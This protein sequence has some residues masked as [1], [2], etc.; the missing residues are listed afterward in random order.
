[1][2][3]LLSIPIIGDTRFGEGGLQAKRA[4]EEE[5]KI[6]KDSIIDFIDYFLQK[7]SSTSTLRVET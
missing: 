6:I 7:T 1:L 2:Y 4:M 3:L 5:K